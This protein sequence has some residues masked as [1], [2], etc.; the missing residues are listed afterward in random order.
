MANIKPDASDI[1]LCG[2]V[3]KTKYAAVFTLQTTKPEK[4]L[5]G[6]TFDADGK[7]SKDPEFCKST[8]YPKLVEMVNALGTEPAYVVFFLAYA[9]A[10]GNPKDKTVCIKYCPENAP[11]KKKMLCGSAFMEFVKA[12][13]LPKNLQ[14]TTLADLSLEALRDLAMKI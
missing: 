7:V 2:E 12:C 3:G 10:E 9:D 4:I 5:A 14:A 1:A 8:S 6:A 11:I 13:N